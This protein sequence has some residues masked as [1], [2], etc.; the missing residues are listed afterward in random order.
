MFVEFQTIILRFRDLVTETGETI[1]AHDSIIKEKQ[2]VWWAWWNKGNEKIPVQGFSTLRTYAEND[3]I[4][5]YLLDSGQKKL[6]KA[7]C[8]GVIFS[9]REPAESPDK[10]LTPEYY[11]SRKYPAW[12]K[13]VKIEECAS[14]EIHHFSY[15]Q[16]DS[17]F[18]DDSIN[19]S[20]FSE[21]R[22]YDLNELIQQN[23]TVWFVRNYTDQDPD[24]EIKLLNAHITEPSDFSTRYFEAGGD[25]LLWLSDLH[26][27]HDSLIPVGKQRNPNKTTLTEHIKNSYAE[28]D[29]LSGLLISGDI[30]NCG[31]SE[32]FSMAD[33]FIDS[34]NRV[35][36][37]PLSSESILFVQAIM[38]SQE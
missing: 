19:Y 5:V 20:M 9:T 10:E 14:D 36:K 29:S 31:K 34:L 4:S 12:F 13:F 23:R 24:H 3:G 30:T 8:A 1:L 18:C 16:V 15:V 17:L 11:R 2:A 27:D 26:F 35:L 28:V 33:E 22:V 7:M 25:S 32:G 21:K 38:T 37:R 6:Y